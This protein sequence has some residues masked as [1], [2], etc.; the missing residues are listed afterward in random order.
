MEEKNKRRQEANT[1]NK[2]KDRGFHKGGYKGIDNEYKAQ[3]DSKPLE[4]SNHNNNHIGDYERGRN[5]KGVR[6]R[7][8]NGGRGP[9][10]ATMK[11]YNCGNSGHPSYR[12]PDKPTSSQ[13]ERRNNY[14]QEDQASYGNQELNLD[15]ERGENLMFYRVLLKDPSKEEPK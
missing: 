7:H 5:S 15:L 11:C 9:H 2:G 10:F 14:V 4:Q 6:R 1:K 12:C 8:N 13:G 3:E